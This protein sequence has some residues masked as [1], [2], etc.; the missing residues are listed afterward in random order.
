[1]HQIF[2]QCSLR[3]CHG[4]TGLDGLL[5]A[6]ARNGRRRLHQ[7]LLQLLEERTPTHS[8]SLSASASASVCAAPRPP[9]VAAPTTTAADVSDALSCGSCEAAKTPPSLEHF[10]F[11]PV[12]RWRGLP[13]P[14]VRHHHNLLMTPNPKLGQRELTENERSEE[15]WSE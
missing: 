5:I 7:Q 11:R 4:A 14:W 9:G 2:H 13:R 6:I 15:S 8:A 12:R 10:S 3:D 1:M